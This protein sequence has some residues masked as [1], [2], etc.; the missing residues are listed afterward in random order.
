[1]IRN[2]MYVFS[3][4]LTFIRIKRIQTYKAMHRIKTIREMELKLIKDYPKLK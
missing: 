4:N 3:T 2:L 1:M